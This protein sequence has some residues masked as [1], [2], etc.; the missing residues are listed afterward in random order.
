MLWN[1]VICNAGCFILY[2]KDYRVCF[3]IC[4]V[5][6]A[7]CCAVWNNLSDQC[8]NL[9]NGHSG[10]HT[11]MK[12]IALLLHS[13]LVSSHVQNGYES[14]EMDSFLN[15]SLSPNYGSMRDYPTPPQQR[16]FHHHR[17]PNWQ[18]HPHMWNNPSFPPQGSIFPPTS[19]APPPPPAGPFHTVTWF[20]SYS[21]TSMYNDNLHFRQ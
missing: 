14:F 3:C 7:S 9:L 18:H 20:F 5:C 12:K 17:G 21:C 10:L 16:R 8:C 6:I 15:P 1:W 2:S 4:E 11:K 13:I 19:Y